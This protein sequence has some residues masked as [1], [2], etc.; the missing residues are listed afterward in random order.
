LSGYTVCFDDLCDLF[1]FD[2][3]LYIQYSGSNLEMNE[4]HFCY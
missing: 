3:S 2:Y 1:W 4:F